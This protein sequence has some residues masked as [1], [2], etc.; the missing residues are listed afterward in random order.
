MSLLYLLVASLCRDH[1]NPLLTLSI[2]K[3]KND[4]CFQ[5]PHLHSGGKRTV[6]LVG[7]VFSLL[8]SYLSTR[9]TT[10]FRLFSRS[11]SKMYIPH[12][13][14]LIFP[15]CKQLALSIKIEVFFFFLYPP[16]P[17]SLL[18]AEVYSLLCLLIQAY[19]RYSGLDSRPLQYH[20]YEYHMNF[21]GF[22]VH[23]KD[24]YTML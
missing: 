20:N 9:I 3:E 2:S 10:Q 11:A 14:F 6:S 8:Y 1:Y 17:H 19:L 16:L 22:P 4:L 23:V 15:R 21:F 18:H 5:P 7:L 24:A 12:R 13:L